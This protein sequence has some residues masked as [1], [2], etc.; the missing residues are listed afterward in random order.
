MQIRDNRL[1]RAICTILLILLGSRWAEAQPAPVAPA[2]EPVPAEGPPQPQ[3]PSATPAAQPAPVNNPPPQILPVIEAPPAPAPPQVEAARPTHFGLGY[4]IGNGLGF[5]GGDLIISPV[6]HVALDLQV[7]SM[8][9]STSYG[10]ASGYGLAPAIQVYFAKP[11]HHTPY[12]DVG[13]VYATMS[14]QNVK[15]SASGYFLNG[16]YEWKWFSGRFC[17]LLGAGVGY[18][19]TIHATDGVT[20]IDTQGGVHF[21]IEVSPRVMFF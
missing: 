11:G 8:S 5:V 18:L 16:G 10:T 19:G 4:K 14:L 12:I 17:L 6:P 7:N 9:A 1:L 20:T 13:Y 21:N 3:A 2:P 15:A